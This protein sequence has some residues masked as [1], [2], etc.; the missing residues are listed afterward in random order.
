MSCA[1]W[2]LMP[3]FWHPIA[4]NEALGLFE[5]GHHDF[6]SFRRIPAMK[7]RRPMALSGGP[8]R[9]RAPVMPGNRVTS[10]ASVLRDECGAIALPAW[11][12][13]LSENVIS[14]A[15]STASAT[16]QTSKGNDHF[17][18]RKRTLHPASAGGIQP[19]DKT[20]AGDTAVFGGQ[21]SPR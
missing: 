16:R 10:A 19:N 9:P 3:I 12:E 17:A 6:R 11:A 20:V 18:K 13:Q 14:S 21:P 7:T 2:W 8:T 15:T 4:G 5:P 1:S